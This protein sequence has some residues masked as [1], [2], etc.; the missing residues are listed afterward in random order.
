MVYVISTNFYDLHNLRIHLGVRM[1]KKHGGKE[2]WR[3][4]GNEKFEFVL[5]SHYST[6]YKKPNNVLKKLSPE[7]LFLKLSF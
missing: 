2:Y 1:G 7:K 5:N 6:T 3:K 4:Y